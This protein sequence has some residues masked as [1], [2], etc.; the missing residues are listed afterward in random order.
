MSTQQACGEPAWFTKQMNDEAFGVGRGVYGDLT[1]VYRPDA[2][3]IG[4]EVNDTQAPAAGITLLSGDN[5]SIAGRQDVEFLTCGG[6]SIIGWSDP[7]EYDITLS[8]DN[9]Q[10]S[11]K[12]MDQRITRLEAQVELWKSAAMTLK[13]IN[14]ELRA[15]NVPE[16]DDPITAYERAKKATK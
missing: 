10:I 7:T 4:W 2:P 15:S 14:D 11:F 1:G 16:E 3:V 12:E 5:M 13:G 8:V 9:R 6:T